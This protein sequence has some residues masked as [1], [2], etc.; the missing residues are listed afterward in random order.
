MT[1]KI[2]AVLLALTMLFAFAACGSSDKED[3]TNKDIIG[4]VDSEKDNTNDDNDTN[5]SEDETENDNN[6]ADQQ[7]SL[8]VGLGQSTTKQWQNKALGLGYNIPASFTVL[9]QD[10]ISKDFSNAVPAGNDLTA[11]L[12]ASGKAYYDFVIKSEDGSSIAVA[13]MNAGTPVTDS[14]IDSTVDGIEDSFKSQYKSMG[15]T[16]KE[17]NKVTKKLGSGSYKGVSADVTY[18]GVKMQQAQFY[19][20]AGKYFAFITITALGDNTVDSLLANF[21]DL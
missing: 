2:L 1:K 4:D 18:M 16:I 14:I 12:S 10:E 9:T 13:F 11:A 17:I 21:Y 3:I 7:A 15:A 8:S 19:A 6:L 20:G 5:S